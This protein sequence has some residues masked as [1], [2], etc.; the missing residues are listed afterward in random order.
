MHNIIETYCGQAR[1]G[2]GLEASRSREVCLGLS[3][4]CLDLLKLRLLRYTIIWGVGCGPSVREQREDHDRSLRGAGYDLAPSM[5]LWNY[6]INFSDL[7]HH[8]FS[9][10]P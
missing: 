5:V 8:L 4:L 3:K 2:M 1:L 10:T 6:G 9:A 7:L